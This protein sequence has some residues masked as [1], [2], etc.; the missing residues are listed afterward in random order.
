MAYRLDPTYSTPMP[1]EQKGL[2]LGLLGV[3]IFSLTLPATRVAVAHFDPFFVGLGRSVLAAGLAIAVLAVTRSPRPSNAQFKAL[4]LTSIGVILGF[5]ALTSWA[6]RH[7]PSAHG[8]IV[9]GL[10]PLA[11]AAMGA[12]RN[13]ERPSAAFW[14]WASVGSGLVIAFA[15]YDGGGA[16]QWADGALLL[17]VLLGAFGYAEG[18]RVTRELGGWQTISWALVVSLPFLLIPVG[19]FATQTNFAAAPWQAWAGFFYV[20][21]LSQYL[22]FFA[23]YHALNIGGIARVSQ[24]Q[25][26]QLFFTLGFAALLLNER[27]TWVMLAFAI[28]VV[29]VVMLGRKAPIRR[30]SQ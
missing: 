11:T 9:V 22:G 3:V 21:V 5:P 24:V 16:L 13:H 12:W 15:I 29:V 2:L 26:L 6:M 20:A 28:A 25:L 1:N 8:A 17:A 10:L 4:L 30:V 14:I 23:W 7:V 19:Y 27:I 18:A